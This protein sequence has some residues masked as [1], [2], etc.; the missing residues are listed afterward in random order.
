MKRLGLLLVT[1]GFLGAAVAS[2][3][4][5]QPHP[6]L[7]LSEGDGPPPL[8]DWKSGGEWLTYLPC[9]LLA[10]VGVALARTAA[11][12]AATAPDKVKADFSLLENS[13]DSV[14]AGL[15]RLDENAPKDPYV[16]P[17]HIDTHLRAPLVVFADAREAILHIH[18]ANAYADGYAAEASDFL[19]RSEDQFQ[20]A[21]THLRELT[22]A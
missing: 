19:K 1:L 8:R 7:I 16:L 5:P 13:L 18:G 12:R 10:A 11:H 20:L 17:G 14:L 4:Q 9:F 2:A 3:W 15:R 22:N 21:R 6:T